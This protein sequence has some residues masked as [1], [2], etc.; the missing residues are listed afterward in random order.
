MTTEHDPAL[1]EKAA[2]AAREVQIGPLGPNAL[3]IAN[4]GGRFGINST[5][6]ERIARAVLAVVVPAVRE[7]AL[8]EA[9]DV[10]REQRER[11]LDSPSLAPACV[12]GWH[13]AVDHVRHH[14][15]DLAAQQRDPETSAAEVRLTGQESDQ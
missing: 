15:R 12:A 4:R 2:R 14:L 6:A 9:Q 8:N 11:Y 10:V 5:E 3:E 7:A 13:A 1:V